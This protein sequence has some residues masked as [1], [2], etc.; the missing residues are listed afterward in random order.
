MGGKRGGLIQL[1][2]W[3]GVVFFQGVTVREGIYL[4]EEGG[5][6]KETL[7]LLALLLSDRRAP[8]TA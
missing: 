7:R 8:L 3:D 1:A 6:S 5:E 4:K 2:G